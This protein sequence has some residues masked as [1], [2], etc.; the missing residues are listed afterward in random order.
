VYGFFGE[1]WMDTEANQFLHFHD[2][3]LFVGQFGTLGQYAG[4]GL[5]PQIPGDLG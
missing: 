1:F 5:Q 2:S 3:G 4:M